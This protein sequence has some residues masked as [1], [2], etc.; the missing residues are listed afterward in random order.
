MKRARI[1]AR[2]FPPILFVLLAALLACS[3]NQ[4]KSPALPAIPT[5]APVETPAPLTASEREIVD[6]FGEQLESIDGER[7]QFYQEF[8]SWRAGLTQC[9]PASAREALQDFAASF[10]SVTEQ[11]TNLPRTTSTKELADLLIPAA[12]AEEATFRQLRDRW[13][14]GNISLF[15]GVEMRRSEAVRAQ[16]SVEDRSLELQEEFEEEPTEEEMEEMEEF[17]D[18]FDDISEA[19]EDY[20]DAYLD[21]REA[22]T[23][24]D[25]DELAG[26]YMLLIERFEAVVSSVSAL[27][28]PGG[29]EDIEEIIEMLQEIAEDELAALTSMAESLADSKEESTSSSPGSNSGAVQPNLPANGEQTGTGTSGAMQSPTPAATKPVSLP[30]PQEELDAAFEESV[31]TLEEIALLI[32]EIA[33]DKSAKNLE[34][35]N[36]FTAS[37]QVLVREWDAFH[38]GYNDWRENDGGCD[39]V[40]VVEALDQFSQDAGGLGRKVR[41]LPQSG[42]LLPIYTLLVEAAERDAA[43]MRN[44]YGSWRPFAVD[45]FKAVDEERVASDRL[46]RQASIALQELRDRP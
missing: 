33:D 35:V 5:V 42:F 26:Q 29:N 25:S 38:Q 20:H 41:D 8:D 22:E 7:D 10:I 44:L 3:Q 9:H 32:E 1:A 2:V 43:A 14:P 31:E 11:T 15:E 40:E 27:S 39:R 34:H 21:L 19:W 30:S 18:I 28:A 16:K 12:E 36:S 37:Y 13:Q 23:K 46:R 6:R 17:S 4:D 45:V 24:L